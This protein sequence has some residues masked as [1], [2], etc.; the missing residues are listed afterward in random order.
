[1]NKNQKCIAFIDAANLMYGGKKSLGWSVDHKKLLK[2]IKEKYK[3]NEAHYYAG[4]DICGYPYNPINESVINITKLYQYLQNKLTLNE[5]LHN[6]ENFT[7]SIQ[8]IKFY[9]KL[10]KFGYTLHL[11]PVKIFHS[12]AKTIKKANCDVDMTFDM[13]RLTNQ[14]NQALILSG[15]GDFFIVLKHLLHEQRKT[16]HIMSRSGRTAKEIR[17]LA[18]EKFIDFIKL[19]NALEY[20]EKKE[21]NKK[22]A[23]IRNIRSTFVKHNISHKK[24]SVK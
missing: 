12:G 7:R 13:M 19:K 14:Y 16:L 4:I 10:S 24:R 5:D 9:R 2:Y 23:D 20:K 3:V 22:G 18:G 17:Q 8:Q 1:M 15:D 11:K 6:V 21:D